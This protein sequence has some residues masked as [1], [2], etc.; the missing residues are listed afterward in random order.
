[1]SSVQLLALSSVVNVPVYI[2]FNRLPLADLLISLEK[3][4]SAQIP[5][6]L[7]RNA[8]S[9][10]NDVDIIINLQFL[11]KIIPFKPREIFWS[12]ISSDLASDFDLFKTSVQAVISCCNHLVVKYKDAKNGLSGHSGKIVA[13]LDPRLKFFETV[14]IGEA[15][16]VTGLSPADF[17][18]LFRC[19]K[20]Y[21]K[22]NCPD[23]V[24]LVLN[25]SISTSTISHK[26]R[27]L[28]FEEP[29]CIK[30]DLDDYD[31]L[32]NDVLKHHSVK[33][34]EYKTKA[35]VKP[36]LVANIPTGKKDIVSNNQDDPGNIA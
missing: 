17:R 22:S 7:D 35:K 6:I 3:A 10:D 2:L 21:S 20:R 25:P 8:N 31:T 26:H 14:I 5:Q 9:R 28:S 4:L 33:D 19:I 29:F 16:T 34:V 1:M 30:I 18:S 32:Y 23:N 15:P 12:A 13:F 36:A 24:T 11:T 27:R